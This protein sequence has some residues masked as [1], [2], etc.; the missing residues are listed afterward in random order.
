M[1]A[2]EERD[3]MEPVQVPAEALWGAQTQHS[4]QNFKK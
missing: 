2:L 1:Q 4:L 3:T